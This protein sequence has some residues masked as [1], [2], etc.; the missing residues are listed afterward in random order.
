MSKIHLFSL[1]LTFSLLAVFSSC[2]SD[3]FKIDGNLSSLDGGEVRIVFS[4]DSG[5]VDE[6]VG[7]DKKGKFSFKGMAMQ[8]IIV[9]ILDHHNKVLATVAVKAGDHIKIKGDASKAMGV[10]IKGNRLNEEWQLFRDEHAAFYTDTNPSRLNAAI[11]KYV[12]EHPADM[13]S[14][15]LLMA[16]YTDFSD[17]DKVDKMLRSIDAAAR[18]KSLTMALGEK[19][20]QHLPRL[21]SLT[22]WKFGGAFEDVKL[23]GGCNVLSFWAKPQNDRSAYAT[24]MKSL[25]DSV[26]VIDILAESD[27]MRWHQTIAGEDWSHYWA[28]AGPMEQGI[29]SLDI[30]SLPW[31]AVTDST[32]L[33]VYSGPNFDEARKKALSIKK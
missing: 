12:R 33:V 5:I 3:G 1:F 13:L 26:R 16:D 27:S 21:L 18:P 8:P 4:G 11:E 14:T 7:L 17:R 10:K 22:L 28:P 31:Y 24:K 32:G 20:E 6:W 19:R 23:T 2:S 9:S 25:S 15:V 30:T 29:T